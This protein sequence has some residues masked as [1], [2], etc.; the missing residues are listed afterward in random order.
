[1]SAL[2]ARARDKLVCRMIRFLRLAAGCALLA[3]AAVCFVGA[4]APKAAPEISNVGAQTCA[5]CHEAQ[6]K[7]WAGS[8][9]A[10]SM[11]PPTPAN[12]LG[13]FSGAD[14]R[15]FRRGDDFFIHAE[16]ADGKPA[17]F[18]VA[19]TFGV[20][21]LQQYLL[22]FSGGRLQAF[23][24]AWDS[25]AKS[26]GGQKWFSLYPNEKILPGDPLHWTG[27]NANWNFMCADCHS[28]G[29]TKNY[30]FETDSYDTRWREQNVAC[31][32]CHGPGARHVAWANTGARAGDDGLISLKEAAGFWADFDARGIRHWQGEARKNPS[33]EICA[34]CHSRRR[35]IAQ[36]KP[37]AAFLDAFAPALLEPGLYFQD[38]Q[39]KD[40]VF[41][42]G[43]FQQSRMHGA[44][45]TCVDCHEPHGAGLR[46][47]GNVLCGQCHAENVF[48]QPQ[49]HHH[50]QGSAGAQCAACH[51]PQRTYMQVHVRHDHSLRL[52]RPA[53]S[54]SLGAPNAC[55]ACHADKTADWAAARLRDWGAKRQSAEQPASDIAQATALA[56]LAAQPGGA[57]L[58]R[59]IPALRSPAP[60][61]RLGA[62]RGLAPYDESLREKLAAPSR[63]D[64]SRAVRIEAARLTPNAEN[65]ALDEWRAAENLAAD[66]PE[67]H[68]NLGALAAERGDALGAEAEFRRAVALDDKFASGWLNLADL[69]RATGRDAEAET[70]LRKALASAPEDA[71]THYA[72][73]L[74]LVRQKRLAEARTQAEQAARLWPEDA[75]FAE[76][77]RLLGP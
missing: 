70:P 22:E 64:V 43:S 49:H 28:T 59:L 55:N 60:L 24:T 10:K 19:A 2:D 73:A 54:A 3:L 16:G 66:R 5:G 44:G 65:P 6:A 45:V 12:V 21:P 9:H 68:L 39:I 20:A 7:A 69:F 71:D 35:P 14:P 72:L 26:E 15:F 75:R 33:E 13:D 1:M 27:R 40:E 63:D 67:S 61:L 74:W 23:P 56:A 50:A 46:A 48:D 32:A 34:P 38:G 77:S 4:R 52:P 17:D 8:H 25:R 47:Q 53:L 37:G 51:M 76:L 57:A 62:L 29:V 30:R 58:Q 11:A 36:Q 42:W 31:E 18:R 41:E